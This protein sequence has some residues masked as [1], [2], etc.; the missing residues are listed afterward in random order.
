MFPYLAPTP[1]SIHDLLAT[2]SPLHLLLGLGPAL[3][4]YPWQSLR[5]IVAFLWT[6]QI[7]YNIVYHYYMAVKEPPGSVIDGLSEKLGERRIGLGSETWWNRYR[8]RACKE[9]ILAERNGRRLSLLAVCLP[10]ASIDPIEE[11][12]LR[13][14]LEGEDLWVNVK[15]CHK[16]NKIPLWQALACLPPELRAVEKEIRMAKRKESKNGLSH[17]N[18]NGFNYDARLNGNGTT[19]VDEYSRGD[20]VDD[21][22][23]WLGDD[24]ENLVAPPKPERTHHC[25]ICNTCVLKFDHHCPW[26]NQCVGIGNERY[27][28]LFMVWLAIGCSVVMFS[29]WRVMLKSISIYSPWPYD[30]TPRMFPLL[31]YTICTLMGIGLGVMAIW[32]LLIIGWGET[33]VESSDN[34]EFIS[35][36]SLIATH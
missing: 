2:Q 24:A 5:W 28:V 14:T 17:S 31:T 9:S 18:G 22:K 35:S 23:T 8:Q 21:I 16:C 13:H 11:Q 1:P 3:C 4:E 36:P 29:G 6:V 20:T 26:L 19:H 15:M 10:K 34:S 30:Y 25:S 27:F 33:S 32:Q 12:E 7:V